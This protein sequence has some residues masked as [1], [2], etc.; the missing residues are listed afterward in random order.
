[1]LL[2]VT[3]I[4][5]IRLGQQ[6]MYIANLCVLINDLRLDRCE[7]VLGLSLGLPQLLALGLKL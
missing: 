5:L 6:L 1:M 3:Q 2:V 7:L 4:F